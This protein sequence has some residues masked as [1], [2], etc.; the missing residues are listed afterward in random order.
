MKPQKLGVFVQ[1]ITVHATIPERS[2]YARPELYGYGRGVTVLTSHCVDLTLFSQSQ[3]MCLIRKHKRISVHALYTRAQL[4]KSFSN[5]GMDCQY[6]KLKLNLC[7]SVHSYSV[8]DISFPSKR[9]SLL[10]YINTNLKNAHLTIKVGYGS[11][12]LVL[13]V[14][15]NL[16]MTDWQKVSS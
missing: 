7:I 10:E 16:K 6:N 13:T 4:E 5:C 9:H 12:C 11:D 8:M 15:T 3:V 14:W 1:V 2:H